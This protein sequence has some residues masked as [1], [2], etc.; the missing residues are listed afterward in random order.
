[1][2]HTAKEK[3][4]CL[5][6]FLCCLVR[7]LQAAHELLVAAMALLDIRSDHRHHP[8]DGVRFVQQDKLKSHPS[9]A[10]AG[11][12]SGLAFII[13]ILLGFPDR[14]QYKD[15]PRQSGFPI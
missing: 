15:V 8:G 10:L 12:Y 1:M 7:F 6:C 13:S 5:V 3:A 11:P 4:L 9:I 2:R 14:K